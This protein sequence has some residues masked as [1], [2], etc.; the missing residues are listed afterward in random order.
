LCR[1]SGFVVVSGFG[2]YSPD[3]HLPLFRGG[4]LLGILIAH[5][6]FSAGEKRFGNRIDSQGG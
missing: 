5:Y 3:V 1:D 4:A 6:K 2:R